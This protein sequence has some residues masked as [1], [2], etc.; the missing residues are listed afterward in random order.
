MAHVTS[1][2]PLFQPPPC[3]GMAD[4]MD[5]HDLPVQRAV[6]ELPTPSDPRSRELLGHRVTRRFFVLCEHP[7]TR[8]R[9]MRLLRASADSAVGGRL[10]VAFLSRA[11]FRPML[12][13]RRVDHVTARVELA[14]AQLGGIAVLRYVTR[15]EPVASMEVEELVAMIGPA[16]DATLTAPYPGTDVPR[17]TDELRPAAGAELVGR[18][19]VLRRG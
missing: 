14:C 4:L 17:Q 3:A 18:R 15:M 9:T 5:P 7:R 19:G 1:G 6:S 11:A 2:P 10:L 16:V 13:S 8:S 12:R